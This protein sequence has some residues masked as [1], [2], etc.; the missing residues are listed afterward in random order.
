MRPEIRCS[1][2]AIDSSSVEADE[3]KDISMRLKS[4]TGF[5]M[6]SVFT[7]K[8]IYGAEYC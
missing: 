7:G 1:I 8:R 2:D 3:K 5:F 6:V 4:K